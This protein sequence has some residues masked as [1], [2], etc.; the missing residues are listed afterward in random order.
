[1]SGAGWSGYAKCQRL[2]SLK[3]RL[4]QPIAETGE[5]IQFEVTF[6]ENWDEEQRRAVVLRMLHG[7]ERVEPR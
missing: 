2:T 1:M 7:I 4:T 3:W 5:T 6:P